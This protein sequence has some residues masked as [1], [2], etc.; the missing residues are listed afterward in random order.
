MSVGVY[1]LLLKLGTFLGP[2]LRAPLIHLCELILRASIAVVV[3][4]LTCS[5]LCV[6][7][8]DVVCTSSS[9]GDK[10][11]PHEGLYGTTR[12]IFAFFMS[13]SNREL[14]LVAYIE[15]ICI[16][17]RS[18]AQV[19]GWM[20]YPVGLFVCGL[21]FGWRW[22]SQQTTQRRCRFIPCSLLLLL[23]CC[24]GVVIKLATMCKYISLK[25]DRVRDEGGGAAAATL[26]NVLIN[27]VAATLLDGHHQDNNRATQGI[28]HIQEERESLGEEIYKV[29]NRQPDRR[30][31]ESVVWI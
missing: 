5:V 14:L 28:A 13:P 7:P 15:G 2:F 17:A 18:S 30:R 26:E 10:S 21:C 11:E 27:W 24:G 20:E 16:Y 9:A 31:A 1:F 22:W 12:N 23:K 3:Q 25:S 29:R 4:L 6:L 8:A 19:N